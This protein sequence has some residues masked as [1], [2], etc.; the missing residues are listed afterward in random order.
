LGQGGIAA[1]FW[2]P[3]FA[4][5]SPEPVA[6]L[7]ARRL[8]E[9][10]LVYRPAPVRLR[11]EGRDL[12]ELEGPGPYLALAPGSGNPLKN[13]PL[14]H[15]Y[16]VSRKLAWQEGLKVVWLLGPAEAAW[17]PYL[18]GLAR[19]QGQV[20]LDRLPL[21]QVAAV[22]ARARLYLGGDSGLTHLAA[23]A[24]ARAVLVL[25]GPT[26]PQVWAP[27]GK[28]VAV[29]TPELPCAPCTVGREIPCPEPRCLKDLSPERVVQAAAR[30]LE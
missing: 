15:Y 30:L 10:G 21:P 11:V 14:S 24:G 20:V 5:E 3:S 12:P 18:T 8:A 2:I 16:E 4:E 27:P 7:Q 28:H 17:L 13:W 6:A 22:L 26:D 19:A 9:L 25:F 29:L 1:V 23:A